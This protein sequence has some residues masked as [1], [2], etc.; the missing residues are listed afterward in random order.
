MT[1]YAVAIIRQTIFGSDIRK[2]LEQIDETLRP[3]SGKFR[4]HGGPY[5]C[6]EGSWNSDLVMIEFPNL[7]Q[8]KHWY[9]SP[10]YQAIQPLR[11][12]NTSGELFFVD[13]VSDH[14][15]ATDIL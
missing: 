9:F 2:Y 5:H 14:H 13:G 7:E 1:A 3:Y 8:A 4:I 11:L 6:V 10:E 15:K 12:A